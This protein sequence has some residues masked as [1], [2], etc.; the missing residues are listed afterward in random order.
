V[1]QRPLTSL[2]RAEVYIIEQVDQG[3]P[4]GQRRGR[5]GRSQPPGLLDL[6]KR[7]ALAGQVAFQVLLPVAERV[8]LLE[9]G[10]ALPRRWSRESQVGQAGAGQLE[11]PKRLFELGLVAC[12]A[13][14][15]LAGLDDAF[16][17]QDVAIDLLALD[18][19]SGC[20]AEVG[21]QSLPLRR[22]QADAL[23]LTERSEPLPGPPGQEGESLT[24]GLLRRRELT[25][26]EVTLPG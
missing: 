22:E 5:L 11:L 25:L 20:D 14:L 26:A 23:A 18:P 6:P 7:A 10:L 1:P 13:V 9:P 21:I 8:E 12:Q 16:A 24:A 17:G 4:Q 19:G 3:G 15:V 2:G